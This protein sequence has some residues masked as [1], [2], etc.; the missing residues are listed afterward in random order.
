M[1]PQGSQAL[2]SWYDKHKRDLPWRKTRDP[3]AIW[4]SEIM[5]QQ[6]QVNTV[7][8]Y[9]VRFIKQFPTI[10]AL[11]NADK[12]EVFKAWEGLGYYRRAENLRQG[13]HQVVAC[14]HGAMPQTLKEL[15]AIKGIGPYSSAAIL[16]I[17]FNVPV[18]AVDGN[19]LRVLSRWLASSRDIRLPQTR[20]IFARHLQKIIPLDRAGDFTQS[21]MELGALV[22]IPRAPRCSICP[23][24]SWC[25]ARKTHKEKELPVQSPR[26]KPVPVNMVVGVLVHRRRLLVIPRPENGL[27]AGTWTFPTWETK[28]SE[29]PQALQ[30]AFQTDLGIQV[31][32]TQDVGIFHHTFTHRKWHMRVFKC[33]LVS[34][35]QAPRSSKIRKW[36]RIGEALP[37]AMASA[38]QKILDTLEE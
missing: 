38:H 7:I 30:E 8:P 22:C 11:A 23:V 35:E 19:V 27:L 9:Y 28:D 37:M 36:I 12:Q 26:P 31:S 4:V 13:A 10:R 2:L 34:G 25:K 18:P 14:F 33:T 5:L 16:S 15:Q 20:T 1:N 17:A 6:T 32:V 29:P 21:L 24:A 3:Y